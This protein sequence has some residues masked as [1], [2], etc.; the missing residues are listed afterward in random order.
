MISAPKIMN[1]NMLVL[2]ILCYLEA[3]NGFSTPEV[4]FL[5]GMSSICFH[6]ASKNDS[7]NVG[8]LVVSGGKAALEAELL[9]KQEIVKHS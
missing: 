8:V 4:S 3:E 2:F 5:F 1:L 7:I 6:K 9:K